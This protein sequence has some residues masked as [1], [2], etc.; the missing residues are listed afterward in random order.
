MFLQFHFKTF[1]LIL[2]AKR[3]NSNESGASSN[4]WSKPPMRDE[5]RGEREEA[6]GSRDEEEER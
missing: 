4:T 3:Q 5:Q 6:E 2:A 1:L